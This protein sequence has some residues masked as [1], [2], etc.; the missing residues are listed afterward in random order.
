MV[1]LDH[2]D[3]LKK[4]AFKDVKLV[5]HKYFRDERGDFKKIF[6]KD[7][8][9][10]YLKKE[11]K[12]INISTSKRTGTVR[13]FHYKSINKDEYKIVTC[14]KGK[15][16]DVIIDLRKSSKTFLK[17]FS[18]ELSDKDN[19]SLLIPRGFAHGF[20]SLI[21][22]SQV[23]YCHTNIYKPSHEKGIN[24]KDNYFNIVWPKKISVIS[25]KDL[26][27]PNIRDVDEFKKYL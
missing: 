13:G 26:S 6:C 5:R 21:P 1:L 10:K 8:H 2:K 17:F 22:N 9:S 14:L 3:K 18:I 27:L 7:N 11:I 16:Y 12:Q 23:L 4:I 19:H 15:I 20:Q 24:V 25:E